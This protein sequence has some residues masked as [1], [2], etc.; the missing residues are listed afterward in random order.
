[1]P[2][3][4]CTYHNNII[5]TISHGCTSTSTSTSSSTVVNET[6]HDTTRNNVILLLRNTKYEYSYGTST[7]LVLRIMVPYEYEYSYKYGERYFY[8][9]LLTANPKS[10]FTR[11]PDGCHCPYN[12]IQE[13]TRNNKTKGR[14]T[15]QPT[16]QSTNQPTKHSLYTPTVSSSQHLH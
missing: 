8:G 14:P 2:W 15:N 10:S 6:Q 13:A 11:R 1:M 5:L 12:Y 16:N 9:S 7:V 3:Y 4:W